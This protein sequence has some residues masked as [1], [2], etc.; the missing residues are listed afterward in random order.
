MYFWIFLV[1]T[2]INVE[3]REEQARKRSEEVHRRIEALESRVQSLFRGADKDRNGLISAAEIEDKEMLQKDLD[4][5]GQISKNEFFGY[6]YFHEYD[7]NK[8]GLISLDEMLRFVGLPD[9]DSR[10]FKQGFLR[11]DINGDGQISFEEFR[12]MKDSWFRND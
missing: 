2:G 4:G 8:D 5:D 7:T 9:Q 3:E 1:E 10:R 12:N 11:A 6:T